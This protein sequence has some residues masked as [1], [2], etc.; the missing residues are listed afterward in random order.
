MVVGI[1]LLIAVTG[2]ITA[3]LVCYAMK[4]RSRKPQQAPKTHH[5]D[6][7]AITPPTP[8]YENVTCPRPPALLYEDVAVSP[9][10]VPYYD[11]VVLSS[12]Q[13]GHHMELK[14]N[15]AYGKLQ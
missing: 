2:S 1:V 13:G 5:Y 15:V 11:D 8:H 10:A 7:V 3:A 4:T 6:D 12:N 9:P 14:E